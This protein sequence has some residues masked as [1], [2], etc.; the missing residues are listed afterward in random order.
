MKSELI[1]QLIIFFVSFS[2][3][4]YCFFW[5]YRKHTAEIFRQRMFA[6]RDQ[7]F[8]EA[9]D[10]LV[11]FDHPSYWILRS[12]MNGFIR[13]GHRI[14]L[15]EMFIGCF[16]IKKHHEQSFVSKL[17]E[18]FKGL[19]SETTEKLKYYQTKMIEIVVIQSVA[20][21]PVFIVFILSYFIPIEFFSWLKKSTV[22]FLSSWLS[23]PIDTME[24][25]A[26]VYGY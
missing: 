1:A 12:T 21:S 13:F 4:W 15:F 16:F 3:L 18:S 19:N 26:F 5:L 22:N 9:A 17:N 11:P 2:V 6:L 8:D 20:A 14:S 7:L 24:S 10:G 25:T 23:K